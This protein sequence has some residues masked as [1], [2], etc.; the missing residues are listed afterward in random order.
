MNKCIIMSGIPGSGKSHWIKSQKWE[1]EILVFSNNSF[2]EDFGWEQEKAETNCLISFIDSCQYGQMFHNHG[3]VDGVREIPP[4]L[5]IDNCN[6]TVQE[7]APYYCVANAY[8]YEVRL[9]TILCEPDLAIRRNIRSSYSNFGIK[10]MSMTLGERRLGY[11]HWNLDEYC[12]QSKENG[13]SHPG[14]K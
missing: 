2:M 14:E 6:L 4:I 5:V 9:I 12:W 10:L 1:R 11:P 7:I 3:H 8:G 13:F